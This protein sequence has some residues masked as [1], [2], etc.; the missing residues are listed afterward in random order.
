MQRGKSNP[1]TGRSSLHG[2][3]NLTALSVLVVQM[4]A[5]G[6]SGCASGP[7]DDASQPF[8]R[9][10]RASDAITVDV[11]F[12]NPAVWSYRPMNSD[13]W[14]AWAS[15]ATARDH[16]SPAAAEGASANGHLVTRIR[17]QIRNGRWETTI[18]PDR[19]EIA[20]LDDDGN[21]VLLESHD[22]HHNARTVYDPPLI[23]VAA[24][25]SPREQRVQTSNARVYDLDA[26]QSRL[27]DAGDVELV[28]EYQTDQLVRTRPT[29]VILAHR[30]H[31]VMT[32]DFKRA[33]VATESWVWYV[34]EV[35]PVAIA[36]N[37]SVKILGPLG[38]R[39]EIRLVLD[40]FSAD[41]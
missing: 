11:A 17:K 35:G 15:E 7:G 14:N 2:L 37:E 30:I 41:R 36:E 33:D 34:P 23:L 10:R 1:M 29:G 27:R 31:R 12:L 21:L 38:W 8:G 16:Q 4:A 22:R 28:V 3:L 9:E 20:A 32:I 26:E 25:Q 24:Q 5:F 18:G 39:T 6:L 40:A 19:S 13:E